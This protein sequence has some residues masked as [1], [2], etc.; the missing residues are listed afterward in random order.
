ML[1]RV[2]RNH[3][4][5][6]FLWNAVFGLEL[7]KTMQNVVTIVPMNYLGA[8]LQFD[9]C[10]LAWKGQQKPIAAVMEGRPLEFLDAYWDVRVT[11]GE[12]YTL[13]WPRVQLPS[14]SGTSQIEGR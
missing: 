7:S 14:S 12:V 2:F 3:R 6:R 5:K 1:I 4:H 8:R 13:A 11:R 10:Q 9:I